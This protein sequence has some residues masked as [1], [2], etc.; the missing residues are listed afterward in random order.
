MTRISLFFHLTYIELNCEFKLRMEGITSLDGLDRNSETLIS[1]NAKFPPRL[2][3]WDAL[4]PGIIIVPS[5][6]IKRFR[7]VE[8]RSC[9]AGCSPC[10][11]SFCDNRLLTTLSL[12]I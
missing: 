9:I 10:I 12:I 1:S 11:I 7:Q 3:N 2:L 4:S 5:I 6:I 8:F